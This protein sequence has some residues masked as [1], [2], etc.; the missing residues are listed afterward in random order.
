MKLRKKLVAVGAAGAL[1]VGGSLAGYAFWTTGG[2]GTG[3]AGIGTDVDNVGLVAT[4]TGT[5]Y[6]G[7]SPVAL[8]IA[9]S[10]PNTYSVALTGET[11]SISSVKCGSTDVTANNWFQLVDS[12]IDSTTVTPAKSGNDNGTANLAGTGVTL[13]MNNDPAASQDICKAGN[14]TFN[15][16]T[17]SAA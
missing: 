16:K 10:N 15:L 4:S 17:A 12:S 2:S 6:P 9:T 7:G 1:V 3:S 13:K 8:D 11:V 14:V 5:L